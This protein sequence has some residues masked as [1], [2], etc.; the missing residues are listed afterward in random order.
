MF[1]TPVKN[2]WTFVQH[3]FKPFKAPFNYPLKH[4]FEHMLNAGLTPVKHVVK[5]FR[6][7]F[8]RVFNDWKPRGKATGATDPR[9]GWH[10]SL[11]ISFRKGKPREQ[12]GARR[13]A[14]MATDIGRGWLV[15]KGWHVRL[16]ALGR[17][18]H[19][20]KRERQGK[21]RRPPTLEGGG[22]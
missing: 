21:P 18:S 12:P 1:E 19:G 16:I 20:S 13:E 11:V 9:R 8:K 7:S 17:G 4:M 3:I 14:T 5:T 10:V 22:A 6:I 15:R 2:K